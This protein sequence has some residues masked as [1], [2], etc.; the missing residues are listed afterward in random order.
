MLKNILKEAHKLTKEIKREYPE[1]NYMAQLGICI[2]YLS[3]NKEEVEMVELEGT[4][5]QIAWAKKIREELLSGTK[6][7][8]VVNA[9]FGE[10]KQ[11]NAIKIL[12][13]LNDFKARLTTE[14]SAKWFIENRNLVHQVLTTNYHGNELSLHSIVWEATRDEKLERIA[15]KL[16]SRVQY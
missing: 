10:S 11:E 3:K 14:T 1:V 5:K 2:S 9:K 15:S 12:K 8:D 13:V 7:I 4:E 16:E 6:I